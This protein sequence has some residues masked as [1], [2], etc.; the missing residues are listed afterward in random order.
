MITD[1]SSNLGVSGKVIEFC[2]P[3]YPKIA[4]KWVLYLNPVPNV[5]STF[6]HIKFHQNS[7]VI[8][9]FEWQ[10]HSI[11]GAIQKVPH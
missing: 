4:E 8:W 5:P 3:H 2:H 7:S 1:I 9:N 10:P 11:C 6:V